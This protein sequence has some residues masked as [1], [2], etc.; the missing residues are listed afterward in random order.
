MTKF[1]WGLIPQENQLVIKAVC[2][3]F[4]FDFESKCLEADNE[5][6]ANDSIWIKR[7]EAAEYAKVST[8]TIDNWCDKNYII[9]SKLAGGRAGAVLIDR[10]SLEKHIRSHVVKKNKESSKR[11]GVLR[12]QH[13]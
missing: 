9:K 8:D 10:A 12:V 6:V 5:K 2:N 3:N 11:K 7:I 1:E 13:S 4:G